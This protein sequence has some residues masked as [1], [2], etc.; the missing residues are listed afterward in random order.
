MKTPS[1]SLC[2]GVERPWI[3][4]AS[5]GWYPKTSVARCLGV[6]AGCWNADVVGIAFT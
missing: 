5:D 6:D 4:I 3:I 2:E 1:T